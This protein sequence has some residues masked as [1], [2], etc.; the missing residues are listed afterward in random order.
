MVNLHRQLC[1]D[2]VTCRE[3]KV[4]RCIQYSSCY[5]LFSLFCFVCV[6]VVVVLYGLIFLFFLNAYEMLSNYDFLNYFSS[7]NRWIH[8]QSVF[9]QL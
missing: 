4:A 2:V 8:S 9:T 5:Y 6:F 3:G 1:L 7:D